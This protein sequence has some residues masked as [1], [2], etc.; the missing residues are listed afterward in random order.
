MDMKVFEHITF[1]GIQKCV[2]FFVDGYKCSHKITPS[3]VNRSCLKYR[4]V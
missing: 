3:I 1:E 2:M 4:L